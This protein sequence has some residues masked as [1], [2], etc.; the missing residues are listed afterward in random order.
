MVYS[1]TNLLPFQF[2]FTN[3]NWC[4]RYS[5]TFWARRNGGVELRTNGAPGDEGRIEL[6]PGSD[7]AVKLSDWNEVEFTFSHSVA[8]SGQENSSIGVAVNG[9]TRPVVVVAS[10][11][12]MGR[13][14]NMI[15]S[16]AGVEVGSAGHLPPSGRPGL[17]GEEER[18]IND[19][20]SYSVSRDPDYSD[21]G[22]IQVRLVP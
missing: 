5:Y 15:R 17:G 4:S 12:N 7:Q 16:G 21:V 3:Y 6:V 20:N 9:Q 18:S 14:T 10:E 19:F 8:A 22:D 11:V 1:E 2:C 13:L